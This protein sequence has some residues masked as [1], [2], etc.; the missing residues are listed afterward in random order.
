MAEPKLDGVVLPSQEDNEAGMSYSLYNTKFDSTIEKIISNVSPRSAKPEQAIGH[1][2]SGESYISDEYKE[3]QSKTLVTAMYMSVFAV[4]G[5][6]FRVVLAQLFGEECANPG[7]VGWLAA[8][9][10]LCVTADG[11]AEREG[12]IIFADLPANIIGCFF[13]GMMQTTATMGLA[14]HVPIAWTA[15]DSWFQ[16]WDILHL[17]IRTGFC[18]SL[19]TFSSW[20]SAMVVMIFGTGSGYTTQLIR[21]LFGYLIGMET[22]LGSLVFGK[23]FAEWIFR[24]NNPTIWQETVAVAKKK[25]QGVYFNPDLPEFERRFLANL[26]MPSLGDGVWPARLRLLERWRLSTEMTRR[27]GHE[28]L[29]TLKAIEKIILVDRFHFSH[30]DDE[31]CTERAWDLASLVQWT[32]GTAPL[33][34]KPAA[35][36]HFLFT[37]A[38]SIAVVLVLYVTLFAGLLFIEHGVSSYFMTYRT[39]VFALIWAPPGALLR[40]QLGSFNGK[41]EGDWSWLPAG[42]L[43]A[44]IFG[45]TISITAIAMEYISPD[46]GFWKIGTLRAVKVGFAGCLTTVST[47][48]A[49]V[50]GFASKQ[51]TQDRAYIYMMLSLLPSCILGLIIFAVIGS[52]KGY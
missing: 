4:L 31:I 3:T 33:P 37:P 10:P 52:G 5:A 8:S 6:F 11:S 50:H 27:V 30:Q 34:E 42:T 22:A 47:F 1:I 45:S 2:L 18:G 24:A 15:P 40:W 51:Q 46:K 28:D 43:A 23:K 25:E 14:V 20:N 12:G 39:M 26:D 16:K 36:D 13:M 29:D 9:S 41:L 17:A 44:N 48:V 19:T 7:T 38:V 21:A 35:N 49:E 32:Q